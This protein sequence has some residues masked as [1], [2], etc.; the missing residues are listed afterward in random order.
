MQFGA[1][2]MIVRSRPISRR[3]IAGLT[4]RQRAEFQAADSVEE[5]PRIAQRR[6]KFE[7]FLALAMPLAKEKLMAA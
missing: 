6:V 3:V 1:P 4:N 7:G 5:T 2:R